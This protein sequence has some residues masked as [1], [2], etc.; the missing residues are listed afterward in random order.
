MQTLNLPEQTD[1][2]KNNPEKSSTTRVREYIQS[3]F[4]MPRI[5]PFTDRK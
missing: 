5:S 4:L 2:C 3:G 1:G